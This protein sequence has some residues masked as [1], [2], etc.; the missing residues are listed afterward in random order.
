MCVILV[1]HY[2]NWENYTAMRFGL[3]QVRKIAPA[4]ILYCNNGL[5]FSMW[6]DPLSFQHFLSLYFWKVD[7]A[8]I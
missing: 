7:K 6:E 8:V 4:T 3:Q 1:P 2:L 5:H